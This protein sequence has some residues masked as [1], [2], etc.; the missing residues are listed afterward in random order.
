MSFQNMMRACVCAA[1][2]LISSIGAAS[3]N[4]AFVPQPS[5][6]SLPPG[7]V[8]YSAEGMRGDPNVLSNDER[9]DNWRLLFDGVSL[10]GWAGFQRAT[11][12]PGWQVQAGV[13]TLSKFL[14]EMPSSERGDLRTVDAFDNFELRLQWAI[15]PGGN[16]GIFFFV[17]EGV[18]DRIWKV[19]PE[20]QILDDARHEDGA[21]LSHRAGALYDI[22][23]PECNAL[24][25]PGEY[26]DVRLIVRDGHVEH[27]LN[28]YRVVQYDLDSADFASR[29]AQS[30]FAAMKQFAKIRRGHV[31]FQD[32]GDEL[33]IRSV[34]IRELRP[35]VTAP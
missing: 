9:R 21:Q 16:S 30:K 32:H 31:A 5:C 19:A 4:S 18:E 22:Y 8:A 20:M 11:I 3:A 33:H 7:S 17:R 10:K 15:A 2:V 12:P 27:W 6:S 13:L 14:G 35:R 26:N 29:L 1:S 25:T 23:A 28:G 24:R 34:R